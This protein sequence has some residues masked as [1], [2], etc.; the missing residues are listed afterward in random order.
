MSVQQQNDLNDRIKLPFNFNV[1]K[2]HSEIKALNLADFIY[3]SVLPLRSPSHIADPSLPVPPPPVSGDYADGSWTQWSDLAPLKNSPYLSSV[4]DTFRKHSKVTLVRLLRLAPGAIVKEH[5]DP[6]LGLEQK[7]SVIRLTIP[8]Q[9]D[10]AVEFYLNNS[11]VPMK[12]GQCW[13]MRLSDPHRI[14]HSGNVERI[15]MS[16]DVVPNEWIKSI[17]CPTLKI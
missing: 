14:I 6:T 3:Y 12:E 16:I 1:E 2:M 4:V 13:Y 8:I 7:N 9:S 5:T 17:I 10:D 15:N 11:I